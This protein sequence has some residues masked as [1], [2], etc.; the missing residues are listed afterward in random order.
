MLV[1]QAGFAKVK[2]FC[3]V[4]DAQRYVDR[5]KPNVAVYVFG[6]I[7]TNGWTKALKWA[8]RL[9]ALGQKVILLSARDDKVRGLKFYRKADLGDGTH[10]LVNIYKM[11][12][13]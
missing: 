1:R 2:T 5:Y 10:F 3:S 13:G 11:L 9:Q 8:R 7:D 4:E 12:P 6:D